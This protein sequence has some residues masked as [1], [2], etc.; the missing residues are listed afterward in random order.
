MKKILALLV[1]LP[2]II[3]AHPISISQSRFPN[4]TMEQTI[5][6]IYKFMPDI[7]F[8]KETPYNK[9]VALA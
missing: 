5:E 8:A 4:E 3:F 2:G 6:R 9:K 1:L 7:N